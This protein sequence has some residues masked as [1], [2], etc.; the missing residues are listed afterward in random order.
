MIFTLMIRPR[1]AQRRGA[2]ELRLCQYWI[3]G[4]T[5]LHWHCDIDP[6]VTLRLCSTQ[7]NVQLVRCNGNFAGL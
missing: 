6:L 4:A 7:I 3:A 2:G 5:L 1:D